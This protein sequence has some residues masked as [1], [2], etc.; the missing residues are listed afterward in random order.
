MLLAYEW[1]VA[2]RAQRPDE[3]VDEQGVRQLKTLAFAHSHVRDEQMAAHYRKVAERTQDRI[4]EQ[5]SEIGR[6]GL[7]IQLPVFVVALLLIAAG[8][9]LQI[10]GTWPGG[11]PAL[12]IAPG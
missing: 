6:Q 4:R 11:I 2:Y 9:L 7:M 1:F 12:G 8:F 5:G 3:F 10:A